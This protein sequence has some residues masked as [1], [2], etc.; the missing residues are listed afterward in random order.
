MRKITVNF[1]I[2]N[3][4]HT[5]H[6]FLSRK[7]SHNLRTKANYQQVT[8]LNQPVTALLYLHIR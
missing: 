3:E 8:S 4:N 7:S 2:N 6:T 1:S 5:V